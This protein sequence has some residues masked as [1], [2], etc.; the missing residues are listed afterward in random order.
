MKYVLFILF[1]IGFGIMLLVLA[2]LPLARCKTEIM[3]MCTGYRTT[4]CR[5]QEAYSPSFEYEYNGKRYSNVSISPVSRREIQYYTCGTWYR[6]WINEKHPI[7]CIASKK[8][9]S[10]DVL[11]LFFGTVFVLAGICC[12]ISFLTGLF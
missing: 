1:L 3:A 8:L 7:F 2:L 6:I 9:R 4:R 11:C 12:A 5:G 10:G